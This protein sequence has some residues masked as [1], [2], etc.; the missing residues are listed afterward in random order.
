VNLAARLVR[1]LMDL[2]VAGGNDYPAGKLFIRY[3]YEVVADM[4]AFQALVTGGV[5]APESAVIAAG[6]QP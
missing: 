3:T 1:R 4:T 6:A 2:P 5:H